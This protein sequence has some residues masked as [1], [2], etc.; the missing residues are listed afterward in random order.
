MSKFH[1]A[2]ESMRPAAAKMVEQLYSPLVAQLHLT[3]EQSK[4]FY[5]ALL[6][7]KMNGI[8]QRSELLSRGDI[9]SMCRTVADFQKEMNASL[10]TLLGEA[11]FAQFQEYQAGVGDRGA[12]EMMKTDFT[13]NP[14]TGEQQQR[15][16][17]AMAAGR[18]TVWGSAT[19]RDAE[20]SIADTSD[21]INQKLI[22]QEAVNENV[23]QQADDFL[24]S[25]QMQTLRT[26][27][28][29]QIKSRKEGH[30]KAREMFGNNGKSS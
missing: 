15:L 26:S 17:K 12:L 23:L 10:Q 4:E 9:G 22:R 27:L 24:S 6:D 20:F 18:K 2:I 13:Q 7:N 25:A 3:P 19:G 1:P 29:R 28:A 14:L 5:R 21:V 8:A 11:N 16:L 30:A